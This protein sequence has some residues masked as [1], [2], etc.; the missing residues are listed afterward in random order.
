MVHCKSRTHAYCPCA[1]V[2]GPL[3]PLTLETRCHLTLG[4]W[5]RWTTALRAWW[6]PGRGAM[7]GGGPTSLINFNFH[8]ISYQ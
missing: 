4:G 6:D 2:W 5:P 3:S 7:C 8:I 1:K